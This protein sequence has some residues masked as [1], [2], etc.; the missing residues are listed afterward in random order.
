MDH[1]KRKSRLQERRA[2][3]DIGGREQP[4]SG[5]PEFYKGDVRKAQDLR[6]ECK[7]TSA[8]AYQLRL[9]DLEKIKIEALRGNDPMWAMQV[10]F[11][12]QTGGKKFAV[13]D[14]QTFLDLRGGS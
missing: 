5:A 11:Q 4:G 1:N 8:Q 10:E 9:I 2:A 13:I 3:K 7:T 14:W 6:V 12:T